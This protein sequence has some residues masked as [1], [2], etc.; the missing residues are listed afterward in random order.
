MK[1]I[2]SR[3]DR[4]KKQKRN[5]T[6]LAVVVLALLVTSTVGFAFFLN[7]RDISQQNNNQPQE[8]TVTNVGGRWQ[9]YTEGQT[10]YLS[11]SPEAVKNI[12]VEITLSLNSYVGAPVYISSDNQAISNEVAEVINRYASRL[13]PACLGNC[14]ED[15][16]EKTCEDLMIVWRDSVERKV[17]QEQNCIFIDGDMNSV[18]AFLYRLLGI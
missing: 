13:Q 2:E 16:P 10:F 12:S 17:S 18:D 9:V 15:L 14:S 3:F 7:P 6:I 4:E 8:G 11:N 5:T 1:K